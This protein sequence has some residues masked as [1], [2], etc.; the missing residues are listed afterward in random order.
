M[1]SHWTWS[2]ITVERHETPWLTALPVKSDQWIQFQALTRSTRTALGRLFSSCKPQFPIPKV[3]Q[4][5]V[6]TLKN[7]LG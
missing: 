1:T 5:T 7:C 6:P 3:G 4:L 2:H